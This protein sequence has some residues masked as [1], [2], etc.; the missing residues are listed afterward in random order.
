ME[1]WTVKT[2]DGSRLDQ[3]AGEEKQLLGQLMGVVPHATDAPAR[4]LHQTSQGK[5]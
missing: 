2:A 3:D 4:E 1:T 5:K